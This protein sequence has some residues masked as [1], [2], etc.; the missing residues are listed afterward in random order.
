MKIRIS[1]YRTCKIIQLQDGPKNLLKFIK[2]SWEEATQ[3]QQ[4]QN[5]SIRKPKKKRV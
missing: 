1:H 4:G 3:N 2:K 5:G